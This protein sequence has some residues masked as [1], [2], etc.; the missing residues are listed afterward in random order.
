MLW[1]SVTHSRSPGWT[2][3][4][5]VRLSEPTSTRPPRPGASFVPD[6]VQCATS[7]LIRLLPAL[8]W[9]RPLLMLYFGLARPC[10]GMR[11]PTQRSSKVVSET[12]QP[13][14]VCRSACRC[15]LH[16][17]KNEAALT[18]AS[19]WPTARAL[20]NMSPMVLY[21]ELTLW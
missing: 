18:H 13:A 15:C 6:L 3:V 4:G 2:T 12:R 21:G 1:I 11:A 20:V 5:L 7:A 17:L 8:A 9:S 19:G 10:T 14:V 16:E